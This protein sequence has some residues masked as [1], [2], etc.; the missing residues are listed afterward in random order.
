MRNN[1]TNKIAIVLRFENPF[2][3]KARE[4]FCAIANWSS[5]SRMCVIKTCAC[6]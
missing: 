5:H 6:N 2:S 4:Y 3:F 1:M